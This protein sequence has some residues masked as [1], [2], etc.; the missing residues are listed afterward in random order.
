MAPIEFRRA[1]VA[2]VDVLLPMVRELFRG[3]SIP[4]DPVR[5]HTALSRL[6][7]DGA[8][9]QV[10]IALEADQACGYAIVTWGYDLE[11]AG[12][13]CFLTEIWVAPAQRGR[14]V[15]ERLLAAIQEVARA[16]GAGAMHLQVRAEN[17]AQHLYRRAG[18]EVSPR[19]LLTKSL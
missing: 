13:D 16:A 15:G 12:R 6:L 11:F 5:T 18:F 8:L 7:G 14:T 1:T 17:P 2:D 4:W 19:L 10:L 3:E 9:G